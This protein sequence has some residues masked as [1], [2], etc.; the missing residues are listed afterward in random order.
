MDIEHLCKNASQILETFLDFYLK[1]E[2]LI[3]EYEAKM[4]EMFANVY[5]RD[6][7]FCVDNLREF[8]NRWKETFTEDHPLCENFKKII[9]RIL[10]KIHGKINNPEY[11]QQLNET[12]IE[13]GG[14]V[15]QFG[16]SNREINDSPNQN[17]PGSGFL[18]KE[19]DGAMN[20]MI[21]EQEG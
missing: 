6:S 3:Q 18:K 14:G 21:Q 16:A 13:G 4:A 11:A 8:L 15:S 7:E 10:R 17:T 5:N 19:S 12:F 2:V 1:E 20:D 9:M